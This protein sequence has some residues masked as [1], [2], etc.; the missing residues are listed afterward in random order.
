M[1]WLAISTVCY[2]AATIAVI[3]N[4]CHRQTTPSIEVR[5]KDGHG[6]CTGEPYMFTQSMFMIGILGNKI[7]I[8][9][10]NSVVALFTGEV[11]DIGTMKI[12]S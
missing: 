9:Q 2:Q 10:T 6:A 11:H 1:F 3:L 5:C 8:I 12:Y 7:L 4:F